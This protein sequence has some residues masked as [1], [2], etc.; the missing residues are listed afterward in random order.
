VLFQNVWA[1]GAEVRKGEVN[2]RK[3]EPDANWTPSKTH[4]IEKSNKEDENKEKTFGV[5][6]NFLAQEMFHLVVKIN[7]EIL[8][9]QNIEQILDKT[10]DISRVTHWLIVFG[11]EVAAKFGDL[12]ETLVLERKCVAVSKFQFVFATIKLKGVTIFFS[13][14]HNIFS[15]AFGAMKQKLQTIVVR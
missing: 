1:V 7:E 14:V 11:I 3:P 2:A 12:V 9:D 6:S 13:S 10:V 4:G 8:E 5:G 15:A